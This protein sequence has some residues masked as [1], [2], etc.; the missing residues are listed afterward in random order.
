MVTVAKPLPPV[1]LLLDINVLVTSNLRDWHQYSSV[2]SCI[3]PQSVADEM[4]LLFKDAV[5]PD[6]ERVAKE[7]HRFQATHQWQS[8]EIIASHPLLKGPEGRAIS[9]KARLSLAV[10]RCAYGVAKRYPARMVVLATNDQPQI[11]RIQA[12]QVPNLC[13]ITGTAL[14]QW[15]QYGRRPVSVMQHWQQMK[16]GGLQPMEVGSGP[17]SGIRS[18]INPYP[19]SD[20][21][22]GLSTARSGQSTTIPRTSSN[23]SGTMA[24]K[25]RRPSRS[26]LQKSQPVSNDPSAV[27]QLFSLLAALVALIIVGIVAWQLIK[28]VNQGWDPNADPP[29]TEQ[30]QAI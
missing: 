2:G 7:F 24:N 18:D 20:L 26:R 29:V 17:I 9:K 16:A 25:S 3:L 13:C 8:T 14:Q 4:H 23:R 11:Q 5:D 30:S 28:A 10:A 1:L 19:A 27:A 22:S 12:L 6:L 15:S 21:Y